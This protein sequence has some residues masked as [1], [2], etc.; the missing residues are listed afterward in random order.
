MPDHPVILLGALLQTVWYELPPFYAFHV[1]NAW[2]DDSGVVKVR[3]AL[4]MHWLCTTCCMAGIGCTLGQSWLAQ[5][6]GLAALVQSAMFAPVPQ[7]VI[8]TCL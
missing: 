1:A 4:V 5:Q 3:Q 7:A 6:E 8:Y 2:E